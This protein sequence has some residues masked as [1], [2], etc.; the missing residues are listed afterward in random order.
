MNARQFLARSFLEASSA[1]SH[2]AKRLKEIS[3]LF[4]F[5]AVRDNYIPREENRSLFWPTI[6]SGWRLLEFSSVSG[7]GPK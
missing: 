7:G 5:D 4:H 6:A 3:S 2:D 1:P